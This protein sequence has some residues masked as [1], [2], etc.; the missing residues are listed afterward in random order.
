M[1]EGNRKLKSIKLKAD[2]LVLRL[3]GTA[4]LFLSGVMSD[5]VEANFMGVKTVY[6]CSDKE[7]LSIVKMGAGAFIRAGTRTGGKATVTVTATTPDGETLTDSVEFTVILEPSRPFIH[8]YHQALTMKIKA[9]SEEGIVNRTFEQALEMIWELDVLTRGIPKIIYLCGWQYDGHDTGY[10]AWDIVN[11]KLKRSQ[12]ATA[13]DSLK[14]LMEEAFKYNTTVSLHINMLD[15]NE[16]SPMWD[17]YVEH[18]L[19]A[20]NADGS[21][22]AYLWGYPI[23]YT[24]EWNAGFTQIRIDQLVEMLIIS[25]PNWNMRRSVRTMELVWKRKWKHRRKFFATGATKELT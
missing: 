25:S 16:P 23:S 2:M 12:D 18:D 1:G 3:D 24:R 13:L 6:S 20:R 21:L 15:I 9:C 5:G 14:W 4:W 11:P 10:P 19:I 17:T 7:V 22:K 8:Q